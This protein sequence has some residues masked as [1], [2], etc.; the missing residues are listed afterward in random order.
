VIDNKWAIKYTVYGTYDYGNLCILVKNTK[1]T[2]E[3]R[4]EIGLPPLEYDIKK[5][6]V[7]YDEAEFRKYIEII[8]E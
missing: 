1:Q 2:N 6:G 3:W 7:K 8:D 5:R 4:K